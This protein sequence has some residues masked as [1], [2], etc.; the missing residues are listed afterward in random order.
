MKT[1]IRQ[2][3]NKLVRSLFPYASIYF[4]LTKRY[5]DTRINLRNYTR[6]SKTRSTAIL[7]IKTS[8]SIRIYYILII[9]FINNI[10]RIRFQT[11]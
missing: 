11:N 4:R 10:S 8:L 2:I 9:L 1:D 6:A 7:I 3:E 5:K